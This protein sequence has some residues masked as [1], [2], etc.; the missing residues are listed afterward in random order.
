MELPEL[1]KKQLRSLVSDVTHLREMQR[2]EKEP[3]DSDHGRLDVVP[4]SGLIMGSFVRLRQELETVIS[5]WG[6]SKRTNSKHDDKH[7]HEEK[8][9]KHDEKPAGNVFQLGLALGLRV[10]GLGAEKAEKLKK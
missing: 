1:Q 8:H 2:M 10:G 4:I 9:Q 7:K 6:K 5:L 3:M